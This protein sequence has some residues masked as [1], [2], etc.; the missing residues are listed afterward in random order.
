MPPTTGGDG[1][2]AVPLRSAVQSTKLPEGRPFGAPLAELAP[3]YRQDEYLIEGVASSFRLIG[4]ERFDG[5]W[6]AEPD[7]TATFRTRI[8][9]TAPTDPGRFC[10]TVLA[11]WN[12]VSA[13][14]EITLADT[15]DTF[16]AG[17][18]HVAISAQYLGVHGYEDLPTGLRSWNPDRYARLDHPGDRYSYDIFAQAATLV[19]PNRPR[20]EADVLDGLDVERIVAIGGSQSAARLATYLNA[21]EP[22]RRVFDAFVPVTWFGSGASL[23]DNSVLDLRKRSVSETV[24]RPTGT[25][26][27]DDLGIPVMVVNSE[28]EVTACLPIRTSDTSTYCFWEVAGT[29]HGNVADMEPMITKM[30]RDGFQLPPPDPASQAPASCALG[31]TPMLA[32]ALWHLERW[33]RGGPPPPSQPLIDVAGDPPDLVRDALGNAT[34]GVRH[35]GVEAPRAMNTGVN[36][37]PGMAVLSGACVPFSD[38]QLSTL[39]RSDED[40]LDRFDAALQRAIDA[41]VILASSAGRLREAAVNGLH[42]PSS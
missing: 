40:Y 30:T 42:S 36:G 16:E 41:G 25:L 23:D 7:D 6:T 27:R 32:A 29:S 38:A 24:V 3:G 2:E 31:W 17:Y 11:E 20:G 14:F 9:V 22:L 4:D 39:Y 37:L 35:P 26:L 34:G 15:I 18:V 28:T 10:G 1:V 13:G 19:G 5:R 12:N 21:V 33:M 8:V